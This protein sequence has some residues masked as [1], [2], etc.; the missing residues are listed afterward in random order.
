M[1]QA[2]YMQAHLLLCGPVPNRPGP[3]PVHAPEVGDLCFNRSEATPG[4]AALEDPFLC[5]LGR[6]RG[7]DLQTWSQIE[8][9]FLGLIIDALLAWIKPTLLLVPRLWG[10]VALTER[11][12]PSVSDSLSFAVTLVAS[13]FACLECDSG[14]CSAIRGVPPLICF[15]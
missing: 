4:N 6:C 11:R 14:L 2:R 7:L 9:S 13:V 1:I 5:E 10:D 3:V 8:G 12:V 15:P